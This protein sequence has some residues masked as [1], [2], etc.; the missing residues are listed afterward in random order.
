M[1][2]TKEQAQEVLKDW[3]AYKETFKTDKGLMK[4]ITK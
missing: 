3:F 4:H 2:Y 1:K